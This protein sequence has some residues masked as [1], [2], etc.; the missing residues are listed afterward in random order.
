MAATEALAW[1]E[2]AAKAQLEEHRKMMKSELAPIKHD[3]EVLKSDVGTLKIGQASLESRVAAIENGT[4]TPSADQNW[5]PTFVDISNFCQFQDAKTSGVTQTEATALVMKLKGMLCEELQGHV[6]DFELRSA[7]NFTV[8][9]PIS[10][11][12]LFEIKNAWND[13]LEL[14]ENKFRTGNNLYVRAQRHPDVQKRL[15]MSG[16]VSDWVTDKLD[17]NL[18]AKAFLGPDFKIMISVNQEEGPMGV[19]PT[20][21]LCEVTEGGKIKWEVDVLPTA[22]IESAKAAE[23]AVK[24]Y[25]RRRQ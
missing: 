1:W 17:K 2:G 16:K 18:E 3:V 10:P 25:R 23:E 5:K 12:V 9:V 13:I 20:G 24:N 7:R 8:R 14:G 6:R 4:N 15:E 22:G 11:S 19:K 21:L